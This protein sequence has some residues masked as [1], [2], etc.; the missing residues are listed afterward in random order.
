MRLS[1]LINPQCDIH[2]IVVA[3]ILIQRKQLLLH[4]L[5]ALCIHNTAVHAVVHIRYSECDV[6]ISYK[7]TQCKQYSANFI[8]FIADVD[9]GYRGERAGVDIYISTTEYATNYVFNITR[10]ISYV[11]ISTRTAA[12]AA[13][14]VANQSPFHRAYTFTPLAPHPLVQRVA[15]SL[16]Y[17]ICLTAFVVVV[18]VGVDTLWDSAFSNATAVCII[19]CIAALSC[20]VVSTSLFDYRIM[21]AVVHS[22]DFYYLLLNLIMGISFLIVSL[23]HHYDLYL[24]FTAGLTAFCIMLVAMFADCYCPDKYNRLL[25]MSL[26][27][28]VFSFSVFKIWIA[29]VFFTPDLVN[30]PLS[31]VITYGSRELSYAGI[32]SLVYRDFKETINALASSFVLYV[33]WYR[34][35]PVLCVC[36]AILCS[37]PLLAILPGAF[38]VRHLALATHCET[39]VAKDTGAS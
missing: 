35:E 15:M 13:A 16:P 29:H 18:V 38:H 22:F 39:K 31:L 27:P 9:A 24:S 34:F 33:H 4:S 11:S 37:H 21:L 19:C 36:G 7:C 14:A 17:R 5:L 3:I 20:L 28:I 8:D 1:R 12:A 25:R 32:L 26:S 30:V 10:G 6:H 2:A 23:S